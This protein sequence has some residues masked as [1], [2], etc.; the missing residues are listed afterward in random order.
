[1][2]EADTRYTA[3]PALHDMLRMAVARVV[4]R[5]GAARAP[6]MA[7]AAPV[8]AR[9]SV[10][11]EL[12]ERLEALVRPG[13]PRR[14]ASEPL[15]PTDGPLE[16]GPRMVAYFVERNYPIL[17]AS[18][19][20]LDGGVYEVILRNSATEV[21]HRVSQR[22]LDEF[23][24][25]VAERNSRRNV[26]S[27]VRL[28]VLPRWERHMEASRRPGLAERYL[29]AF[30]VSGVEFVEWCYYAS[31][32]LLRVDDWSRLSSLETFMVFTVVTS[33]DNVDRHAAK[34]ELIDADGA[35]ALD[36]WNMPETVERL[37]RARDEGQ[38]TPS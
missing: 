20:R 3:T 26:R 8:R 7:R 35:G 14:N 30:H 10:V 4:A 29:A 31:E 12:R 38:P 1:M 24:A 13:A 33:I 34:H 11:R 37:R 32:Y 27:L 23:K 36:V 17:Y 18:A 21:T 2:G 22:E 9:L 19:E 25:V 28:S 6:R 16:E 5:L 15:P